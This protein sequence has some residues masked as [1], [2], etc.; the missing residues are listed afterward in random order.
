LIQELLSSQNFYSRRNLT[1][2]WTHD[3][4]CHVP[5]LSW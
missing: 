3:T 1:L 4:S 5:A 2:G